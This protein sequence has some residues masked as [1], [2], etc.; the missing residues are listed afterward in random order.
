M[1]VSVHA[2]VC[3][4]PSP[5]PVTPAQAARKGRLRSCT[6]ATQLAMSSL[7]VQATSKL[8]SRHATIWGLALV[9]SALIECF[10]AVF[11]PDTVCVGPEGKQSLCPTGSVWR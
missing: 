9:S 3:A 6:A 11:G 4:T 5:P 10:A 2:S 1:P 8:R 7:Q